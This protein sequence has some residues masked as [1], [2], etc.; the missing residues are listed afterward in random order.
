MAAAA[1]KPAIDID[2]EFSNI[3]RSDFPDGFVFGTGTAAYQTEGAAHKGGRGPSIWDNFCLKTPFRITDGSNGND[4]VDMYNRFEEDFKLMKSMGFDAY[5]FSISWPRILPGGKLSLGINQEGINFYNRVIDCLLHH[6]LEPYATLFHWD[7]PLA[8]EQE[9]RGFMSKKVVV[10]FREFA[11]VCFWNFGDRVKK[12]ATLNEP[13]SYAVHGYVMGMFPPA[14]G[15][16][17]PETSVKKTDDPNSKPKRN[18]PL[19][20]CCADNSHLAPPPREKTDEDE[21]L[22]KPDPTKDCYIVARNLLLAHAAAVDSYR[23]KFQDHQE[24]QIGITI[25]SYWYEPYSNSEED[26]KSAKRAMDFMLGWFLEPTLTGQYPKNMINFVPHG[27]L[28]SFT[29]K[30]SKMLKGSIDFLGLNYYTSNYT[31]N[32][33]HAVCYL[34]GDGYFLDQQVA[35]HTTDKNGKPIGPQAGSDWQ[36]IVPWGL[37]KILQYVNATYNNDTYKLPPVY[38]TENGV[39]ETLNHKLIAQ[40]GC[41]DPDRVNFFRSHLGNVLKAIKEDKVD[42]R[43]YFLWSWCDNFEWTFG[44]TVRFG[45]IYVDYMNYMNRHPKD[46][47]IWFSKFLAKKKNIKSA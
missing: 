44:Y 12:W 10:D 6:G 35:F 9:Y 17:K 20:R 18:Y 23:T 47:A 21:E 37:H 41:K 30:E 11:E 32:D 43:G 1:V 29:E 28:A 19:Y 27:N 8:L 4:A 34:G 45:I 36:V 46:S 5:R 24:G 33:P 39:G 25:N 22:Q 26:K 7:L 31:E 3:G 14:E 13:W 40:E 42:V 15:N 16:S 38:I 2:T